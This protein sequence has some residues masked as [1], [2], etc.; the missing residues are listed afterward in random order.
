MVAEEE[1]LVVEEEK[2]ILFISLFFL[3]YIVEFISWD[4]IGKGNIKG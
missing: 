1:K 4:F 3:E 2:T